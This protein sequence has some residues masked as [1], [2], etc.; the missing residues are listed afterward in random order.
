MQSIIEKSLWS[1]VESHFA[2]INRAPRVYQQHFFNW[3]Q[4]GGSLNQELLR[5]MQLE[6]MYFVSDFKDL[7]KGN[8][9]ENVTNE[10]FQKT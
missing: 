3:T 7:T 10:E 2:D 1:F 6:I 5:W 4:E 8:L 9:K